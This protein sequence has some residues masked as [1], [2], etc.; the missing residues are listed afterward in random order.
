MNILLAIVSSF[1]LT[2]IVS[3]ILIKKPIAISQ[4]TSRGLHD[5]EIST[6]GGIAIF[7]GYISAAILIINEINIYNILL[8]LIPFFVV[9]LGFLDDRYSITN[10]IRFLFQI[11]LST[12]IVVINTIVLLNSTDL[13]NLWIYILFSIIFFVYF[14]NI[15]NFMDGIDLIATI[16]GL[17]ILVG[18]LS[19][20]VLM[21]NYWNIWILILI[22]ALIAF[23]IFNYSPAKLFLGSSGSYLIALLVGQEIYIMSTSYLLVGISSNTNDIW[24]AHLIFILILAT[25]FLADSTYTIIVRFIKKLMDNTS[26]LF[27]CIQYITTPHRTHNYQKL[28]LLYGSHKKVNLY[29]FFYNILWCLPL[30]VI[31]IQIQE[32][33]Y[34][35]LLFSYIPYLFW[36]YINRAGIEDK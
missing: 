8:L 27:E 33:K 26:T 23:I 15:Y 4:P 24:A 16:Q 10:T 36:C 21:A 7:F 13:S 32:Y 29:L 19:Y 14:I 6:S 9:L 35:C 18:I 1:I 17:F 12:L 11:L 28:A 22:P 3:Y 20:Y 31:C 25:I 5:N 2:L 30:A 34:L